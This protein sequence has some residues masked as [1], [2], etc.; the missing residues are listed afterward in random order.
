MQSEWLSIRGIAALVG[1]LVL[2]AE[3][4]RKKEISLPK[5]AGIAAVG[6]VC[7]F[8]GGSWVD[9]SVL[10]QFVPGLLVLLLAWLSRERIGYGDGWVILCLGCYLGAEDIANLCMI[11][12]FCAGVVSLFMLLAMHRGR[13]TQIPFVPFLLIGYIVILAIE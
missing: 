5:V 8:L 3:D 13:Q 6:A 9:V 7:S 1:L 10:V 11:A 2:S 12:L 4:L